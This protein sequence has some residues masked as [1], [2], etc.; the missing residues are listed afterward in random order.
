MRKMERMSLLGAEVGQIVNKKERILAFWAT[1]E[2]GNFGK[3]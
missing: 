3:D 2:G 1:V